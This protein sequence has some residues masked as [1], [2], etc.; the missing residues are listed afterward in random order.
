MSIVILQMEI[1]FAHQ[2]T[3][4]IVIL[5]LFLTIAMHQLE[6]VKA[7]PKI[8]PQLHSVLTRLESLVILHLV[9]ASNLLLIV[10][11][12]INV[13]MMA[14]MLALVAPILLLIVLILINAPSTNVVTLSQEV[15]YVMPSAFHLTLVLLQV[16]I[17]QMELVPPQLEIAMMGMYAQ[18]ILVIP[19][20]AL[21]LTP[22]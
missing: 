17:L 16:V 10:M 3:V 14:V 11:M 7:P 5:V 19:V 21:V 6:S 20:L 8:V 4:T 9:R 2:R 18:Q 12:M 13:Q 15:V 1:V 22:P